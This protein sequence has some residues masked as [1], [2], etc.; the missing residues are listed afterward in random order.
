VSELIDL[1]WDDIDWRAGTIR[2]RRLK[3]SLDGVHILERDEAA[4]LRRL[5]REQ[6]PRPHV[7][8]S[9]RGQA[10]TRFAINKMIEA[11]GRNA[12]DRAAATSALPT[13]HYGLCAE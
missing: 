13:S 2:V 4:G 1:R 7:F 12:G 8:T 9:E 6:E 3:G 5:Q 11:A 10:L